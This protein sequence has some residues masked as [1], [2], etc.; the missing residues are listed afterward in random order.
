MNPL[1]QQQAV[2]KVGVVSEIDPATCTARV[3]F[4]DLDGLETMRLPIGVQKSLKDKSYW[5]PD[6]GEHVACLLDANAEAGVILCAIYSE[7]DTPPI[8]DPDK[9][10][11]RFDD[12]TT[13][14]YDRKAH[15]LTIQC[16]GEV[17]VEAERNVTVQSAERVNIFGTQH[18]DIQSE[19]GSDTRIGVAGNAEVRSQGFAQVVADGPLLIK[20][21][22][23]LTLKGPNSRIDL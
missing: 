15:K 14:E 11:V 6:V 5:M 17:I 23:A 4:D 2:F 9:K 7:Q 12:G 21:D 3:R 19:G 20:S 1:Q 18:V 10:H 22:T 8:D 13:V 16:V